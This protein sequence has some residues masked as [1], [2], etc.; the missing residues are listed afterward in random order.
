M[1]IPVYVG[2]KDVICGPRLEIQQRTAPG[3]SCLA[4]KPYSYPDGDRIAFAH[5][6]GVMDPILSIYPILSFGMKLISPH[7]KSPLVL[8]RA[9]VVLVDL[10]PGVELGPG[11]HGIIPVVIGIQAVPPMKPR[12]SVDM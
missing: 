3:S 12:I 6:G 9:P 5:V 4:V 2:D 10:G 11:I 8:Y 7:S 1:Q